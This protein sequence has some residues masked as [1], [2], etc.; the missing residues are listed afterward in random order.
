[1]AT[2]TRIVT[3]D[4]LHQFAFMEITLQTDRGRTCLIGGFEHFEFFHIYI[5]GIIIPTDEVHH[6][7]RG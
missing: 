1:M 4:P 2:A 7:E 5:L 6:F 3:N